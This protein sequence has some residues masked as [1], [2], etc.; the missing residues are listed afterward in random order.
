MSDRSNRFEKEVQWI[1]TD[2]SCFQQ[3]YD[4]V[5]GNSSSADFGLSKDQ[6]LVYS[7]FL[8]TL[9]PALENQ[10]DFMHPSATLIRRRTSGSGKRA[11]APR[12]KS[13]EPGIFGGVPFSMPTILER[14]SAPVLGVSDLKNHPP[15]R[16]ASMKK[17]TDSRDSVNAILKAL[18]PPAQ[19]GSPVKAASRPGTA[20]SSASSCWSEFRAHKNPF[21]EKTLRM[22]AILKADEEV[23]TDDNRFMSVQQLEVLDP[24]SGLAGEKERLKRFEDQY[25]QKMENIQKA[26][27]RV[28]GGAQADLEKRD[29]RH[30]NRL[31]QMAEIRKSLQDKVEDER[32]KKISLGNIMIPSGD[33][34]N[35]PQFR[36]AAIF[37]GPAMNAKRA[38][39]Y[40]RERLKNE[41]EEEAVRKAEERH[42]GLQAREAEKRRIVEE[43]Q[44][45]DRVKQ[46]KRDQFVKEREVKKLEKDAYRKQKEGWSVD[47]ALKGIKAEVDETCEYVPE[48]FTQAT[49]KEE[50]RLNGIMRQDVRYDLAMQELKR[51]NDRKRSRLEKLMWGME[52]DIDASLPCPLGLCSPARQRGGDRSP[53]K[54]ATNKNR[55]VV[56]GIGESVATLP[57]RERG[58][59]REDSPPPGSS[60][61]FQ[62]GRRDSRAGRD[63]RSGRGSK[64]SLY[65]Q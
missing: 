50:K 51:L 25:F 5:L 47:N 8:D 1:P 44:D 40:E 33:M 54:R 65:S 27:H 21:K 10:L 17:I 39:A 58:R 30:Q 38:A 9:M 26:R 2:M 4:E 61:C 53:P 41:R 36:S 11:A 48:G 16:N 15:G 31:N 60:H 63:S 59:V 45:A 46:D 20:I 37:E 19:K 12:S 13:A 6:Q 57:T 23:F 43:K 35:A 3:A 55:G 52:P 18:P 34:D 7:T 14:G 49:L 29:N 62:S 24:G 42:A 28:D 32:D 64:Q 22:D 56:A